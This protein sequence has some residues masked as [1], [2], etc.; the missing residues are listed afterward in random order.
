MS[1]TALTPRKT[2]R[3]PRAVSEVRREEILEA[4]IKIFSRQGYEA[5]RAEDIAH[6]ANIAKGTLYLYFRSKEELYSAAIADA[7]RQLQE[8][9]TEQIGLAE[10]FGGKLAA[11]VSVRLQFWTERQSLYRLL[12]TLGREPRHRRQTNDLL[13]SGQRH[14]L[15]IFAE[16]VHKEEIAEG[17]YAPLAW[18]IMDM[19]RGATERRMDRCSTTTIEAD[20]AAITSFA[21]KATGLR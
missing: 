20:T 4:A 5:A 17:N 11:A 6:A 9:S 13:R 10:G 16:G 21:R 14:L 7:V 8:L 15:Q 1:A 19:I 12:L 3:R 2:R 18:A